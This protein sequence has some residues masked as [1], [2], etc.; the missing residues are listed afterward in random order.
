MAVRPQGDPGAALGGAA[1]CPVL[2]T[3]G[4]FVGDYVVGK[5]YDPFITPVSG[6]VADGGKKVVEGSR[7]VV[8]FVGGLV[9]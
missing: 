8:G 6:V 2:I 7:K 9:R 4:A 3:D 5:A 1:T